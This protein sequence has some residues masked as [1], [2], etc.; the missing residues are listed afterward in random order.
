MNTNVHLVYDIADY[1]NNQKGDREQIRLNLY[2][3][4]PIVD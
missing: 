4:C 1:Y 2:Y 3:T